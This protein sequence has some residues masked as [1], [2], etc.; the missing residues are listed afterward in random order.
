M[1]YIL[2][3]K[4]GFSGPV[5]NKRKIENTRVAEV[6]VIEGCGHLVPFEAPVLAGKKYNTRIAGLSVL[7]PRLRKSGACGGVF[8]QAG[9]EMGEGG[10]EG[11]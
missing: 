10:R 1:L 8:S 11:S 6:E 9:Q 3:G 4:S 7:T 2:G 5:L